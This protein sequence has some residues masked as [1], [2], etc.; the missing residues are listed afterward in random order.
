MLNRRNI[1]A[2]AGSLAIASS[3]PRLARAE[4]K[5]IKIGVL[6]DMS[7]PFAADTGLGS[8]VSAKLAVDDFMKTNP[9]SKVELVSGDMQSKP[10]LCASISSSWYEWEN[11]DAIVDVPSSSGALAVASAAR[12]FNKVALL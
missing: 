6:P 8:V 12:K 1:L 2:A 4:G 9:G 3:L 10:D 7:G 11:V 5:P